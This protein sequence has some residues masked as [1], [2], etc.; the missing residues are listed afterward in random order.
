MGKI[1]DDQVSAVYAWGMSANLNAQTGTGHSAKSQRLPI[2]VHQVPRA[3]Q[4]L[5]VGRPAEKSAKRLNRIAT[6]ASRQYF[7]AETR[8]KLR[9]ENVARLD[10]CLERIGVE[11]FGPGI[12]VV[13]SGIVAV[14]N[15]GE[16]EKMMRMSTSSGMPSRSSSAATKV[17][18]TVSD[19]A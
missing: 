5:R 14:E 19:A 6:D 16:V 17:R 13:I 1:S 12:A 10:E 15:V 9:I 7:V 11:R 18:G 8:G 2:K 3:H 4:R